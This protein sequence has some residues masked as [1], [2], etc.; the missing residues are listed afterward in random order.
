[1]DSGSAFPPPT[2]KGET[3]TLRNT[4]KVKED[5][6]HLEMYVGLREDI[7]MKSNFRTAELT[8]QKR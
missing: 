4:G 8:T 6:Q 5:K 7:G 1:M 3:L 2:L